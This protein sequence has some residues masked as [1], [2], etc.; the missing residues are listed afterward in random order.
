MLNGKRLL[1][2]AKK[3]DAEPFMYLLNARGVAV[4]LVE[5]FSD[6][7]AVAQK[8]QPQ[9]M[10]FLLPVYWESIVDLVEKVKSDIDLM[11]MQILYIGKL[12]E[13]GDLSV[14]QQYGVKT[15]A[16][17]PVPPQEMARFMDS[18][19]GSMI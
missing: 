4:Q 11:D 5:D 15:M 6:A 8:W 9:V 3:K 16:L 7:F 1:M 17:G 18:M 12:I 13:G 14:L 2:I 10:V 19:F